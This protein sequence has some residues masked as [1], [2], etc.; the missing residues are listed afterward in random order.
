MHLEN[1]NILRLRHSKC[2]GFH[3]DLPPC[4][5][6]LSGWLVLLVHSK[7]NHRPAVG[8]RRLFAH[9]LLNMGPNLNLVSLLNDLLRST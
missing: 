2:K 4:A 5:L 7:K 6:N 8:K 1:I 9:A 3:A